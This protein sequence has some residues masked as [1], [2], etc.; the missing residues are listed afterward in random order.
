MLSFLSALL[1]SKLD[2]ESSFTFPK[3]SE[4]VLGL[5]LVNEASQKRSDHRS[6]QL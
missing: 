2:D 1:H 6:E 4:L 3:V 5:L